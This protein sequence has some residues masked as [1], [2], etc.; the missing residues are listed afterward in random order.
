MLQKLIERRHKGQEEGFTLIELM[1]VVLIIAI[2]I[3]IAIPT[4]L[5]A[6]Q[7]AQDRAAQSNARNA[8]TAEKTIY[9]DSQAYTSSATTLSGVEPSLNFVAD[10]APGTATPNQV[11]VSVNAA[12]DTVWLGVKSK[13]NTC[14]YVQDVTTAGSAGT[15][16]GKGSCVA[17]SATGPSGITFT[18]SW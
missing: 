6:R 3:A 8:L 14:F 7:R 2:L 16:Y 13:S 4:F 15:T 5:G 12:G 10:S 17:T 11:A 18:N 9:T 1:V